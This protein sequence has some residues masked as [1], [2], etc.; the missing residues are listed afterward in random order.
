M[1]GDS[2]LSDWLNFLIEADNIFF[3]VTLFCC[4]NSPVTRSVNERAR[5]SVSVWERMY[6]VFSHDH[7]MLLGRNADS[8]SLATIWCCRS[9]RPWTKAN[10]KPCWNRKHRRWRQRCTATRRKGRQPLATY[11]DSGDNRDYTVYSIVESILYRQC[12]LKSSLVSL[13]TRKSSSLVY[14]KTEHECVLECK[15]LQFNQSQETT[16][17]TTTDILYSAIYRS[18]DK[19]IVLSR[20]HEI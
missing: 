3:I 9:V 19:L 8:P 18:K 7:Q 15:H 6:K 10:F 12:G 5:E 1:S 16:T 2:K 17:T 14:N 20:I 4:I 13:W 11:T